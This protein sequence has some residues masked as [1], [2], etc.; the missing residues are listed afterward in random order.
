MMHLHSSQFN[1]LRWP[2]FWLILLFGMSHAVYSQE[3][4][5]SVDSLFHVS[6]Q[7]KAYLH[8]DKPFYVVGDTIWM[9]GYLVDAQTHKERNAESRFLYVELIDRKEKVILRKK[10]RKTER[11]E[12]SNFFVIDGEIPEG[13]YALRAYTQFM[14]NE[15]E[16]LFFNKPIKIYDNI[17]TSLYTNLRF[18]TDKKNRLYA[19]VTLLTKNGDPHQKKR[20]EY[21]VRTKPV[22]NRF[23]RVKTDEMGEVRIKIPPKE[24]LSQY[25]DLTMVDKD[26]RI[27][28]KLHLPDTYDYDVGFYPEG[29]YLIAGTNQI[30]AF[31]AESTT[32][33]SPQIT[34]YVLSQNADTLARLHS[35]HEG[36]GSFS[37]TTTTRDTLLAV[38]TDEHGWKKQFCLPVPVTDK[39]ALAV[40]QND[41]TLRYQLLVPQGMELHDDLSLLVHV[42][43]QVVHTAC[44]SKAHLSGEIDKKKLPEGVIQLTVFNDAD[45]ALTERLAFVWRQEPVFQVAFSGT[46]SVPR[47]LIKT[48]MRLVN[49]EGVPLSGNF[50]MSVTDDFAIEIDKEDDNIRSYLLMRSDLRGHIRNSGYYFGIPSDKKK[51]Q[52]DQL[53][54]TQGWRSFA[55]IPSLK[56]KTT[57]EDDSNSGKKVWKAETKQI[58]AGQVKWNKKQKAVRKPMEILVTLPKFNKVYSL[59]T[60][61]N[62][63]F[64]CVNNYPDYTGFLFD[65]Q[66]RKLRNEIT[67]V[68]ETFPDVFVDWETAPQKKIRASYLSEVHTGLTIRNGEKVYQLPE[69]LVQASSPY[70]EYAYYSIG[71]ERLEQKKGKNALELLNQIPEICIL[72][73][74]MEHARPVGRLGI[75]TLPSWDR[76]ENLDENWTIGLRMRGAM[77]RLSNRQTIA[78]RGFQCSSVKVYVDG[79]QVWKESSLKNLKAEDVKYI[80]LLDGKIDNEK[81][82]QQNIWL[83]PEDDPWRQKTGNSTEKKQSIWITTVKRY[84]GRFAENDKYSAKTVPLSYAQDAQFYSPKYPTEESR[85]IVNSD[86]RSTIHWE[87]NIRLNDKGEAGLSFYT[88]DR[89]ST[90]TVVIEG[91][92]D[93]GQVC[94]YVGRVK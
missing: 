60:D 4:S 35:E 86:K 66:N 68:E 71:G 34:G 79:H 36:V 83:F 15:S 88:A 39:I 30:I 7:E 8:T 43:G 70:S 40:E 19:V 20:V 51:Q 46:S 58:I 11:G 44:F 37:L 28:R 24:E 25:I 73:T 81:F 61:E 1:Y 5:S 77:V 42:R 50:S 84:R 63:Y 49:E 52:L 59:L 80:D 38:V 75:P 6:K 65:L 10:I 47:S 78:V 94:R 26:L 14:R 57:T 48:G 76:Y 31:K 32:G 56:K 72:R 13:D 92:T 91:I 22:K 87:P 62:G 2:I 54:L 82:E 89:P 64:E 85:K 23:H 16:E 3:S 27:N 74:D 55:Q 12:F 53:M 69:V 18:E 17:E 90:Y 21:M 33:I 29:G 45:E 41:S 9:K 67:L 93:E